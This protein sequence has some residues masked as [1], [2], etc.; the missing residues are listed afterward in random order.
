MAPGQATELLITG[1]ETALP[2]V[3]GILASLGPRHRGRVLVEVGDPADAVGLT[4]THP[5]RTVELC[6]RPGRPLLDAV[7]DWTRAHG[8]AAARLGDRFYAWNATESTRVA[9]LRR[10]LHDAGVAPERVHAQ[11]Y[12]HDRPRPAAR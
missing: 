2:A 9:R 8:A 4:A 5:G 3:R 12:W 11:G 6:R 7:A 1:D 10:M